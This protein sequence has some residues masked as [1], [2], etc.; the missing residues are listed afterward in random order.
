MSQKC[1]PNSMTS[2]LDKKKTIQILNYQIQLD[3]R[4]VWRSESVNIRKRCKQ[5]NGKKKEDHG[6]RGM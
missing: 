3:E 6:I 5:H 4:R 1:F 2:G